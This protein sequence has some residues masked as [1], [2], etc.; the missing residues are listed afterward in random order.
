M[1]KINTALRFDFII[2]TLLMVYLG[3]YLHLCLFN[4]H[5]RQAAKKSPQDKYN[6]MSEV[7]V[8]II[9]LLTVKHIKD[10]KLFSK[11]CILLVKLLSACILLVTSVMTVFIKKYIS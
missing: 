9:N 4:L 10:G 1:K 6:E 8:I 3:F 5:S 11:Q 7:L 2:S